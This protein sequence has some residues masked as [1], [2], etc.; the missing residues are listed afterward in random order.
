MYNVYTSEC[1][2]GLAHMIREDEKFHNRPSVSY[3][4]NE[5]VP[6][7]ICFCFLPCIFSSRGCSNSFLGLFHPNSPYSTSWGTSVGILPATKFI[8]I[9]HSKTRGPHTGQ[10]QEF[11]ESIVSQNG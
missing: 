8:P 5:A 10:I 4:A 11:I 3:K 1:G 7:G 9:V 2:R 6:P